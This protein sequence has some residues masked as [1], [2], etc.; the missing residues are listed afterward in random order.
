MGEDAKK[1]A[2]YFNLKHPAGYSSPKKLREAT[3]DPTVD[4][5]LSSQLAYSLHKPVR[6]KFLT[7]TYKTSGINDLWQMDLMEMIPYSRV[8]KGYK[9][10]LTCIDVFSRFAR[11][12]P[13]KS[14][15]G[16][17]VAKAISRMLKEKPVHIQTDLGKEF[18]NSHVISLLKRHKIKHYSVYSQFKAAYV[19]RFNRTLR[20]KLNRYFTHT[21]RKVWHNVIQVIVDTYNHTK[22]R[23]LEFM[24]PIDITK[25]NES[26]LWE[27]QQQQQQE[28]RQGIHSKNKIKLMDYVRISRLKGPFLKNFDQNWSDEV[29]QVVGID[30]KQEPSMYILQ[31]LNGEVVKGK[32]YRQELQSIGSQLPLLYRIEKI[33]RTRGKGKHKQYYVKWVGYDSSH[34]SWIKASNVNQ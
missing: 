33:I 8:N 12:Q 19:E 23:G 14:K 10:I 5:W 4:Q 34:N 21:G 31:D 15:R 13:L 20:E 30:R 17:E 6:K 7:R 11:V 29:F 24:R 1:E 2:V 9:Y 3:K 28:S 22:H 16:D 18:Y 25:E 26:M 27:Q 32:F